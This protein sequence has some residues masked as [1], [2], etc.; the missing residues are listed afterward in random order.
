[1]IIMINSLRF[2]IITGKINKIPEFYTIF[3]R[4]IPDYIMRQIEARP[5]ANA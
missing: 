5:R 4:I 2:K 1:M 3:V